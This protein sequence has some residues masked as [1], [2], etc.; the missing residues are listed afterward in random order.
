[1]KK[2]A[3]LLAFLGLFLNFSRAQS[4]SPVIIAAAGTEQTLNYNAN[5]SYIVAW[6]LG[7][8]IILTVKAGNRPICQGFHGPYE[9]IV[10]VKEPGNP[11]AAQLSIFPNPVGDALTVSLE[12][13][14]NLDGTWQASVW[15]LL[16]QPVIARI[17]F[18][19]PLQKLDCSALPPGVYLLRVEKIGQILSA[20]TLRFVKI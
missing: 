16:G 8:P 14:T 3:F 20:Q 6:T 2:T 13:L 15:N 18:F 12:N 10:L 11:D 9:Q 4:A 1:M 19:P 17:S 5:T 7:E